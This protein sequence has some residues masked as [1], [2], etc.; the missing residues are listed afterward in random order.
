MSE[1]KQFR[2]KIALVT[3]ASRGLGRG[4]ALA[5]AERGFT[6]IATARTREAVEAMIRASEAEARGLRIVPEQVDIASDEEVEALFERLAPRFP[7]I[8]VLVN[9]AGVI[10][11]HY[12]N[13]ALQTSPAEL[14]E[15]LNVNT[16]GA[17][18]M[19]QKVL[20]AM[21]ETGWGRIVNVSSGMGGL[22]DMGSGTPAYRI[23]KTALSAVT[24]QLHAAA[25]TPGVKVNV[26]CPGWVRTD[27]GGAS[28]TRSVDEGIV[29]I[30]W[31]ATLPDDGPSGGFFRDGE[32]LPW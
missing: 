24:V 12:A 6:V 23:S 32:A 21:N 30:V 20:P 19:S 2:D 8:D 11:E 5:L 17:Y 25:H 18:R 16:V 31:A 28:A 7:Q 14:L 22:T 3:G 13:S 4:T 29:G 15:T 27:M 1:P 10:V 26:V 9:N